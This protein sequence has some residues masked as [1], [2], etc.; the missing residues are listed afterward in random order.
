MTYPSLEM[1]RDVQKMIFGNRK[2]TL[3]DQT[4]SIKTL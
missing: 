3:V 2:R 1:D 4:V